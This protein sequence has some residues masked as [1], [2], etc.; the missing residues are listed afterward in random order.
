MPSYIFDLIIIAILALFAW[1]GASRGLILTLCGLAAIFVAWFGAQFL[2]NAF[3]EPVAGI[4]RPAI[5]Q[6]IEEKIPAAAKPANPQAVTGVTGP[7]TETGDQDGGERQPTYT[8]DHLMDDIR[9]A[10]LFK[11]VYHFLKEAVEKGAVHPA[12]S[13][14]PAEAVADYIAKGVSKSVLFALIFLSITIGWFLLSHALDLAF[15]LPILSQINLIGGLLIGLVEASLIV[16]VLV[17]LGQVVDW[18]PAEPESPLLKLFT[19]D[20]LWKLWEDLP[21]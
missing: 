4:I 2:S 6:T 12:A 7:V 1:R 3:C 10:G 14:T 9:D 18:I 20:N 5:L 15:K 13:Q 21:V 16:I 19:V 8:V 17:W 11:G